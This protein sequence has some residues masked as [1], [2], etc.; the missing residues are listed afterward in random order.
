MIFDRTPA[1]FRSSQPIAGTGGHRS[2]V[3]P[4]WSTGNPGG[5]ISAAYRPAST[6]TSGSSGMPA[7]PPAI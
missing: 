6:A 4:L 5:E 2:I 7:V 1:P 3:M